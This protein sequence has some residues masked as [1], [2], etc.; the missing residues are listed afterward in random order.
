[1]S[2]KQWK[3]EFCYHGDS[4]VT[5]IKNTVTSHERYVVSN[6]RKIYCSVKSAFSINLLF[7]TLNGREEIKHIW[8][9]YQIMLEREK[10]GEM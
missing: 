2:H 10:N 4:I 9:R 5:D 8:T 3:I 7:N 6:H 1:M